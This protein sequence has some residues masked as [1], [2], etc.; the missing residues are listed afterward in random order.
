MSNY[1]KPTQLY[2]YAAYERSLFRYT[3]YSIILGLIYPVVNDGGFLTNLISLGCTIFAIAAIWVYL[4][5]ASVGQLSSPVRF[6][7][8]VLLYMLVVGCIGGSLSVGKTTLLLTITQDLRFTSLFLLGGIYSTNERYMDYF[9]YFMRIIAMFAVVMGV[10]SIILIA[11]DGNLIARGGEDHTSYHYWWASTTCFAYCGL[12]A[13]FTRENRKINL[14]AFMAYFLIGISFLK[15]SCFINVIIIVI[16]SCLLMTKQGKGGK[17]IRSLLSVLLI[18][19]IIILFIPDVNNI[20]FNALFSRF[21]ETANDMEEFDRLL[22]W[23]A[24]KSN[25]TTLQQLIGYGIGNYPTFNRYGTFNA[26]DSLLNSL[27]LGYA[28]I[29]F[30]GGILYAAFYVL[31]YL[32]IFRNWFACKH[33]STRYLVCFGVSISSLISLLY[34]GSWTYTILPFCISAPIF[35]VATHTGNSESY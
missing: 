28:N 2:C 7:I 19:F 5:N 35:Y 13:F 9:H 21:S 24:F 12:C 32:K 8:F 29:I 6:F 10:I 22:E 18:L 27:H 30:K 20:I 23:E 16:L 1:I 14:T 34:E 17:M 15:R 4:K 31:T 11:K 3:L 26:E 33:Y 25:S